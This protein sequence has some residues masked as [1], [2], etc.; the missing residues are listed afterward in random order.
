MLYIFFLNA[1]TISLIGVS[2]SR[3]KKGQT[4]KSVGK[5]SADPVDKQTD[6]EAQIAEL[7]RKEEFFQAVTRNLSE[8]IVVVNAKG[9]ITYVSPSVRQC[10]GYSPDE[11]IGKNGFDYIVRADLPRALVDFGKA[12][13]SKEINIHNSFGIR[14]KDGSKR[15]MGG[16]GVNLLQDRM[17]RGFVINVRDITDQRLAEANLD[18]QQKHLERLVAKRTQ[19]IERINSTLKE[20]LAQRK[21]AEKALRISENRHR[22]FIENI[23][24]GILITDTSG[25]IRYVN[26]QLGELLERAAG[27]LEGKNIFRLELFDKDTQKRLAGRM[28]AKAGAEERQKLSDVS[29]SMKDKSKKWVELVT[30]TLKEGGKQVGLQM[31]F[32]D[33]TEKKQAHEERKGLAGRLQWAERM[34]AMGKIAGGVAHDINNE[35]GAIVGYAELLAS[36]MQDDSPLRKLALG[37]IS[38][39]RKA[40]SIL[41]NMLTMAGRGVIV[42]E[43]VNLSRLV[44]EYLHTP[45]FERLVRHYP[46][47]KFKYSLADDLG[48]IEGAPVLLTKTLI[49]LVAN[50]MEAVAGKGEVFIGT[51]NIYLGKPLAGYEEVRKGEYV[52]LT[53]ADTGRGIAAED[54][55]KIFEPSYTKQS[56][57]KRG[58][59]MGLAIVWGTVK[60]HR[61]YIEVENKPGSGTAFTIYLP[62]SRPPA[63]ASKEEPRRRRYEGNGET[64]LV[65]DDLPEQREIAE[66]LLTKM[67]YK[68]KALASGEEAIAYLKKNQADVLI[69]DMLMEPGI[70]GLETYRRILKDNPRQKAVIVSGYTETDRARQALALGASAFIGKPYLTDDIGAAIRKALSQQK[71]ERTG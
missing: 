34:E 15:I 32:V 2:S 69:L 66:A 33:M 29:V 12:I 3:I 45:E 70:D 64:V 57:G 67:G 50:A 8:V 63:R 27:D 62:S 42:S 47:V 36:K 39:S 26:R 58:T 55:D 23:P 52:A 1:V 14:H 28:E 18:S 37:L 7:R 35:L 25:K 4:M 38:S 11:L 9:V 56:M 31:V 61:G 40:T 21:E 10:L 60:D 22:R 59:G 44:S 65:V 43:P 71:R 13:L 51:K 48:S 53:V 5:D 49:N 17:V 20:E 16:V 54:I 41:R 24:L 68:V 19:E 46:R 6:L 30:T